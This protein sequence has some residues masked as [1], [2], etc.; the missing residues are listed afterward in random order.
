[1]SDYLDG[2]TPEPQRPRFERMSKESPPIIIVDAV[3]AREHL[4]YKSSFG[5]PFV[6]VEGHHR[7]GYLLE[8]YDRGLIGRKS[9][10]K[11]VIIEPLMM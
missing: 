6:L 8:R 11:V 7:I 2:K 10:H 3:Y 9:K 4:G 5:D 1:M